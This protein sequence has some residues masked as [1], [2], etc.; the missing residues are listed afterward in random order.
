MIQRRDKARLRVGRIKG[1][2]AGIVVGAYLH[3]S[4]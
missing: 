2:V 1:Y 4:V 3:R